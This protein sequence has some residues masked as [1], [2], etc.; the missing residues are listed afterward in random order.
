MRGVSF[1]SVLDQRLRAAGAGQG[2]IDKDA[3][4]CT[5]PVADGVQRRGEE[6]ELRWR[7]R[8]E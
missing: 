3:V 2:S 6:R 1:N 7:T 4:P 8:D 5:I